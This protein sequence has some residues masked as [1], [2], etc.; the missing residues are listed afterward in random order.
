MSMVALVWLA[1]RVAD[2]LL[3]SFSALSDSKCSLHSNLF[4]IIACGPVFFHY[5]D[6]KILEN[7]FK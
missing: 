4:V 7:F 3:F 6:I 5:F 2:G 1:R